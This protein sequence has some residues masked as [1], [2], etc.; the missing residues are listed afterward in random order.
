MNDLDIFQ[1]SVAQL[2]EFEWG[3]K[4]LVI[5]KNVEEA[6]NNYIFYGYDPGKFTLAVL[7]NDL[8]TAVRTADHVNIK[9]LP[10]IVNT[11][12]LFLPLESW[13]NKQAYT[14]WLTD[15]DERRSKF[16]EAFEKKQMWKKLSTV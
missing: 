3:D 5:S 12:D 10:E 11:M 15:V 7:T 13:G 8:K 16:K 9:M 2:D 14:N 4:K 1:Y 6:V